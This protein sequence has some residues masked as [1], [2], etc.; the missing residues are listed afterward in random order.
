MPMP[1]VPPSAPGERA[2]GAEPPQ[3]TDAAGN[4]V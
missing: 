4:P 2:E 3:P 1:A